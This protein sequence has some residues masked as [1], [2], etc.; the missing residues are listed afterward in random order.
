MSTFLRLLSIAFLGFVGGSSLMLADYWGEGKIEAMK[1]GGRYR[2]TKSVLDRWLGEK[3][4]GAHDV[5]GQISR[6][7][8]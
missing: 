8:E 5:S 6:S 4:S 1:I 2:F 3:N 7:A